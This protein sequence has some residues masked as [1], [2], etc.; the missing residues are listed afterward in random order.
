SRWF[1]ASPMDWPR[2]THVA[3]DWSAHGGQA[4]KVI[5]LGE[6]FTVRA[7]VDKGGQPRV[8]LIVTDK[9]GTHTQIMTPQ[10]EQ[11]TTSEKFYEATLEP[12][13]TNVSIR[14]KAGDDT[15]EPAVSI[16]IA[17]RPRITDLQAQIHA[18]AYVKSTDNTPVPA[19]AVNLMAQVGRATQG[20]QIAIRVRATKP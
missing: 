13:G 7:K 16:G 18:P 3:F 6:K 5:P 8:T 14:V 11:N 12:E 4:P 1:T 17:L 9:S 2:S 19:I 20:A 15:D 10:R